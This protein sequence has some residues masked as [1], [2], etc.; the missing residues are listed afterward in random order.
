M[1]F[2]IFLKNLNKLELERD[3]QNLIKGIYKIP[4]SNMVLNDERLYISILKSGARQE[5]PL[6]TSFN[7]VLKVIARSRQYLVWKGRIQLYLFR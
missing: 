4:I 5:Y 3:F 1:L 6:I 7:I 2:M